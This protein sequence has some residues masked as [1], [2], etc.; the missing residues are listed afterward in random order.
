[1]QN[2]QCWHSSVKRFFKLMA[3]K[4]Y[5]HIKLW[6]PKQG[7]LKTGFGCRTIIEQVFVALT[8]R[9]AMSSLGNLLWKVLE[10]EEAWISST[11]ISRCWEWIT[12]YSIV[13]HCMLKQLWYSYITV[14]RTSC[15]NQWEI[16]NQ[17]KTW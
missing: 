4:N 13:K 8:A 10:F 12:P 5:F 3:L 7:Y 16:S 9:A 15:F 11:L 14:I 1:M 6:T 2:A 17:V